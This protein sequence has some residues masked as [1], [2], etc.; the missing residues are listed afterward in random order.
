[1]FSGKSLNS[2]TPPE[3]RYFFSMV[4]CCVLRDFGVRDEDALALFKQY[5]VSSLMNLCRGLEEG[6]VPE[7]RTT[8]YVRILGLAP[9]YS[10]MQ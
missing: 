6:S 9:K 4:R 2:G 8:A 3:R 10:V 1:M 7:L 5:N